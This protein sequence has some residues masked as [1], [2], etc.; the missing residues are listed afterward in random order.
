MK[1][2]LENKQRRHCGLDFV[3]TR[4]YLVLHILTGST[5]RNRRH[6]VE[7]RTNGRTINRTLNKG[8]MWYNNLIPN[9]MFTLQ[10]RLIPVDTNNDEKTEE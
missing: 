10:I 3:K 2:E 4:F 5:C 9:G 1:T 8:I 7:P 6:E